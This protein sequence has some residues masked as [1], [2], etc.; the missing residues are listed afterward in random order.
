M[1]RYQK[2]STKALS[3]LVTFAT[4]YLC[5]SGFYFLLHLKTMYQNQGCEHGLLLARLQKSGNLFECFLRRYFVWP[6]LSISK[7]WPNLHVI[8]HSGIQ[9]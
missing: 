7:N 6:F 8:P 9:T 5:E 2:L 1:Q 3:I 4:T